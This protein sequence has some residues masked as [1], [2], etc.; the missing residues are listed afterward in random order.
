MFR[1]DASFVALSKRKT[2]FLASR[3]AEI[4]ADP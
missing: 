2:P 1:M 4:E 3:R